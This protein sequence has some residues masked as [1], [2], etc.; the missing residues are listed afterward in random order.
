M[1]SPNLHVLTCRLHRQELD[2]GHAAEGNEYYMERYMLDPKKRKAHRMTAHPEITHLRHV[3][4]ADRAL[5]KCSLLDGCQTLD[6]VAPAN[7]N[8]FGKFYDP[9][10]DAGTMYFSS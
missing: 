9:G 5:A 4:M 2:R 1:L 10:R 3:E 7:K 8:F 6:E